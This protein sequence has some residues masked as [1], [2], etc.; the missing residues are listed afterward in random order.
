M[1]LAYIHIYIQWVRRFKSAPCQAETSALIYK[2]LLSVVGN[3]LILVKAGH[4]DLA[5][6]K[7]RTLLS[8]ALLNRGARC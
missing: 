8:W 3:I 1:K 2:F 4:A 7:S 6:L 5:T